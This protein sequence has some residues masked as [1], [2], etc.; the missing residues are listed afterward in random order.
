MFFSKMIMSFRLTI[1]IKLKFVI[2]NQFVL[3]N[4]K[5]GFMK[6]GIKQEERRQIYMVAHVSN[7]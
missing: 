6:V 5:L 1:I 3:S 7:P 2:K 4:N